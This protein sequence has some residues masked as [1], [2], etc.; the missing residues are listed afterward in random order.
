MSTAPMLLNEDGTASMA[1]ALLM[2]HHGLRRDLA[3]FAEALRR[4]AAGDRARA[5]ALPE[6]WQGYHQKLHGHHEAEDKGIFPSIVSQHP[7]V[8]PV[9]ERLSADHRRIDPLLERGDHAF[10]ALG[11][12]AGA[13]AVVGELS[14]LLHEHLAYEEQ[15]VIRFLRDTKQF[16]PP[17]SDADA[18][19]YA[20]GFAWASHG[21]AAEVLARLDEMLPAS[22]TSRLPAARAQ[23]SDRCAR[24]WGPLPAGAS[25]TAVPDWLAPR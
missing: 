6:E 2:S 10:A 16:P 4:V 19:L 20:Q 5:G 15:H 18:E 3:L 23:F 22:L 25:R 8:T 7:E 13:A 11:D 14:A 1:T 9:I 24:V 17:P 12:G 21:V